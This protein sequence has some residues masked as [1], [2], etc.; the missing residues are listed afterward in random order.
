VVQPIADRIVVYKEYSSY[1]VD[2]QTIQIGNYYILDP[3][4]QPI[5]TAVGCANQETIATVEND[6]FY[7]GRNGVYVTGYEPNFLNIIRTNEVSAKIRP[8][9][10][11]L[12][13][14]DY[15]TACAIYVDNK[16]VLSFPR[17]KEMMVYDRERGAWV[18]PWSFP[19][20]V[21][22]MTKYIDNSGN[23]RWV[24]GSL[25]DNKIYNFNVSVNNDNGTT[26]AKT[27]RLNKEDMGEWTTLKI[28]EFFYFLFRNIT[29][30]TTVNVLLEDKDGQ[31]SVGKSFTI[32]GAEVGGSTGWGMDMWGTTKYGQTNTFSFAMA[33]D[34]VSPWGT[35]FKQA[36]YIQLEI[37]TTKAGS[38]FEFLKANATGKMQSKG[39]LASSGRV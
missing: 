38:N 26:I 34:E 15:D 16:Y 12:N 4:Y 23:E 32:S 6:S 31:T 9:L 37:L 11:T 10:A 24:L 2:L 13:Q 33:G 28:I 29:G 30:E 25:E 21:N 14:E 5:S 18:G 7:F 22:H 19:F 36:K 1:L 8:Y 20:G 17:R 27:L 39:A 35:I 3:Q